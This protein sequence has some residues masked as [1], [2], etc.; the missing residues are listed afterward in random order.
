MARIWLL[1]LCVVGFPCVNA[2]DELADFSND[3]ATDLGPLLALFGDSVTRQ[4]LSESTTFLDYFIFAMA[5]MGIIT[6]VISTI[7]VCGHTA[8]RALVGRSQEGDGVVES[9]LCTSTS[10][11]VCELFNKGGI[12]RVLGRPHILELIHTPGEK[13]ELH[14]FRNYLEN[15]QDPD[16]SEWTKVG[17]STLG[18]RNAERKSLYASAHSTEF[19]PKPNLSLNVGIKKQPDW[20]FYLIAA[21]GFVF[22]AGVLVLAGTGVWVLGWKVEKGQAKAKRDYAPGIYITGT[23]VMCVGMWSCAAL[24][25]Q[26]TQ[27]VRYKRK[28]IYDEAQGRLKTPKSRLIYLQPGPQVIGDQNFDPFAHFEDTKKDPLRVWTSS[29]KNLDKKFELYTFLAVLAVLLGYV[30]QFIG[31]R[32]LEAWV[33]ITQLGIT[34]VMSFL[35]G[36]LRMQRLSR[37]KNKLGQMP[38]LSAGHELDWL[39]FGIASEDSQKGSAWFITSQCDQAVEE[40]D[41]ETLI[42]SHQSQTEAGEQNKVENES[43]SSVTTTQ[44]EGDSISPVDCEKLLSIRERLAHLTG[45]SCFNTIDQTAYQEWEDDR[46]KIRETSR[47]LSLAICQAAATLLK[48]RPQKGS[49]LL[50]AQ[51]NF[52]PSGRTTSLQQSIGVTLKPPSELA[53]T[54]WSIDSAK[55]EAILGLW[56]WSLLSDKNFRSRDDAGNTISLAASAEIMRVVSMGPDDDDW[57]HKHDKQGEMS[58]W[59][60]SQSVRLLQETLYIN[61]HEKGGLMDV[62]HKPP[63]KTRW[64]KLPKLTDTSQHQSQSASSGV[65]RRFCGWNVA[66][67][68]LR[69]QAAELV[70]ATNAANPQET[71]SARVLIQ[72]VRAKQSLL[73]VCAQELFIVLVNSL[74]GLTKI[75]KTSVIE[76]S[77]KVGLENPTVTTLATA[78]SEN[79][80]GFYSEALWCIVPALG[81]KLSP[82]PDD[83]LSASIKGANTYRRD[84]EWDRAETLLRWTCD[85]FCSRLHERIVSSEV[86]GRSN[87]ALNTTAEL[88]RWSLCQTPDE[89]RVKY[90]ADGIKWLVDRYDTVTRNRDPTK[91]SPQAFEQFQK[92]QETLQRYQEVA[93]RVSQFSTRT[94]EVEDINGTKNE[95]LHRSLVQALENRDRTEALYLLCIVTGDFKSKDLH[96]AL[97]LAARNNWIDMVDAI[98]EKKASVDSQDKDG[99][100]AISHCAELGYESLLKRFIAL[101]AFLERPDT[102]L[103]TPLHWAATAGHIGCAEIIIEAGHVDINRQGAKGASPLH[104]AALAQHEDFVRYLLEKGATVDARQNNKLTPLHAAA[105]IGHEGI[106]KLLLKN[107]ADVDATNVANSTPIFHAV[108]IK[109]KDIVQILVDHGANIDTVMVGDK[110]PL[111]SAIQTGC[112]P[113]VKLLLDAGVKVDTAEHKKANLLLAPARDG[114]E[115][116]IRHLLAKDVM[117]CYKSQQPLLEAIKNGHAAIVKLLLENGADPEWQ[118]DWHR[119]ALWHAVDSEKTELVQSIIERDVDFLTGDRKGVSPYGLAVQKGL[120]EILQLILRYG[121][122]SKWRNRWGCTALWVAVSNKQK[123]LVE[124]LLQNGADVTVEDVKGRTPLMIARYSGQEDLVEMILK[125]SGQDE[126]GGE[127]E[128]PTTVSS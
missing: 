17:S 85:Q 47:K 121:A 66:H 106:L 27:E 24:I 33:S 77:D 95:Q 22:Q 124:A 28:R 113:I 4:Y 75:E 21:I 42:Q 90:G 7:R 104:N 61:G 78:F 112:E 127:S 10:R 108:K 5:P 114:N 123:D 67:E 128:G 32:G 93:Q 84:G 98:L 6:A 72:M 87:R 3:L 41:S 29:K 109:H 45:H 122:K 64:R 70:S 86:L 37:D 91:M 102:K 25:G 99:R 8:L 118:D 19:A 40:S 62:W 49:I 31:L 65:R 20:L 94:K 54:T 81:S 30:A 111:S 71:H 14:I 44:S 56:T 18:R 59:L 39:S 89:E 55:I 58:L 53:Q 119:T 11:D 50:R 83:L 117:S 125:Y 73:N 9:E 52:R 68:A 43:S 57:H 48:K 110:T 126:E 80:L 107:G 92:I 82:D 79:G 2:G 34:L 63:N 46:V 101:G 16:T 26:T 23:I 69:S 120:G 100:T 76:R 60:G 74:L 12:T 1:F 35:R 13:E 88:Y 96:P 97:P 36:L 103:Q 15:G 51:A 115:L 116:I 38:D 105:H